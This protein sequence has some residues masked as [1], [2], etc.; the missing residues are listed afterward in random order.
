MDARRTIN[1]YSTHIVSTD[2]V[3]EGV[4]VYV[5]GDI[6]G[7][8]LWNSHTK[9]Y[10]GM[11]LFAPGESRSYEIRARQGDSER[12]LEK[13]C[14]DYERDD[15]ELIPTLAEIGELGRAIVRLFPDLVRVESI[16][17]FPE[18]GRDIKLFVLTNPA[19]PERDKQVV[20]ATGRLHH[21]ENS[22]VSALYLIRELL[23]GEARKWLDKYIVLVIPFTNPNTKDP[24]WIHNNRVW[25]VNNLVEPDGIA[26]QKEVLDRFKP[27]F[28]LDMHSGGP[29]LMAHPVGEEDFDYE[30]SQ[31]LAE[32]LVQA[33]ER[34]GIEHGDN[35]AHGIKELEERRLVA[36]GEILTDPYLNKVFN[37]RLYAAYYDRIRYGIQGRD[38]PATANDY[39]YGYCHSISFTDE[40]QYIQLRNPRTKHW[41]QT[42]GSPEAPRSPVYKLLQLFQ[43][44]QRHFS[45]NC[46]RGLPCNAVWRAWQFPL[47][48]A[49]VLFAW[50]DTG[51]YAELRHARYLL[52]RDRKTISLV[53]TESRQKDS[54]TIRVEIF[55]R[56][57]P[58]CKWA[59]RMPVPDGC[60][61]RIATHNE[62][63]FRSDGN[64]SYVT[65]DVLQELEP[66]NEPEGRWVFLPLCP[67]TVESAV[68][69]EFVRA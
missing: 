22:G 20:L 11:F 23:F 27:E 36:E 8:L 32:E 17:T 58:D 2:A 53:Q 55:A 42:N 29:F 19:I 59:F 25:L 64:E 50:S 1:E 12:V 43:A 5:T 51:D 56:R 65:G 7:P 16:Y 61:L 9:C 37:A 67:Q 54:Y 21:W 45:G 34:R 47:E 14:L 28:W 15:E 60:R 24:R 18:T 69:A 3:P 39:G 10:A 62:L 6:D 41:Y 33:A 49:V 48:E 46:H 63:V 31:G 30:W 13:V 44:G 52:W 57:M 35:W 38:F 66:F 68:I 40:S 4:T 26:L